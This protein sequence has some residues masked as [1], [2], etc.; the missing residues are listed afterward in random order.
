MKKLLVLIGFL[1]LNSIS[2]EE[3]NLIQIKSEPENGIIH[4]L[5]IDVDEEGAIT[6]IIRKSNWTQEFDVKDLLGKGIVLAKRNKFN[7]VTLRCGKGCTPRAGGP[8]HLKYL[9]N[10]ITNKMKPF[11]LNLIK[12]DGD[13]VLLT[14]KGE[15]VRTLTIKSRKISGMVVGIKKILV[16]DF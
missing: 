1:F 13:W 7:A 15:E 16:N 10:A 5:I 12:R 4:D 6:K 9:Y 2:A 8:L 11:H 14:Q 3:I